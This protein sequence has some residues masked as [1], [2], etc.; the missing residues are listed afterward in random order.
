MNERIGLEKISVK[1]IKKK[2]LKPRPVSK[3]QAIQSLFNLPINSIK[4][5]GLRQEQFFFNF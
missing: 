4:R 5:L 1:K 3:P 2:M